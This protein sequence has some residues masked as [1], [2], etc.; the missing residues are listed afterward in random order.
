MT[1]LQKASPYLLTAVL[2][3]AGVTH[4]LK[5]GF[6]DPIV[7]HALPGPP[8]VWTYVSGVAELGVAVTVAHPATRTR[9]ALAA[10]LL[11]IAVFPANVQM[12]ADATSVGAKAISYGRLPLQ[13]PLVVWAWKVSRAAGRKGSPVR[14]R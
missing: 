2:A 10:L 9:G 12:A 5:P 1:A 7:P 3:G 8:R 13:L 6:Y 11:F 4:F 14:A